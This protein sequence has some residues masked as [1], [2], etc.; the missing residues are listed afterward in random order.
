MSL[1]R[2]ITFSLTNGLIL[3]S[4]IFPRNYQSDFSVGRRRL[5][6]PHGN[7]M[8]AYVAAWRTETDENKVLVE[9]GLLDLE[10]GKVIDACNNT[11]ESQY[12]G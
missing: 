7:N 8:L 12:I 6:K 3:S 2:V 4:Q 9:V 5:L 10:S 11:M 1:C